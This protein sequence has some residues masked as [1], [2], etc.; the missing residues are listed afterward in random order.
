MNNSSSMIEAKK[1]SKSFVTG[2]TTVKAV[3]ES[4]FHI[5]AGEFVAVVG[6]SGSGK[7]TLLALLGALDH[8]TA[9]ELT[10]SGQSVAELRG[11]TLLQYRRTTIGFVFQN[12]NLVPNLSALENV[13]L[14][15][16]FAGVSNP[17]RVV[18]AKSLLKQVGLTDDKLQR[19]PGKL[20][21]GEQQR[22]AI[23]R[24]LANHPKL[25]LADEPTGNLD[26]QTSATI[27]D[28]LRSLV[29]DHQTTVMVVTH[30]QEI[31]K[32]ADRVF[33]IRDGVLHEHRTAGV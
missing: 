19:T 1:L 29:K 27:I 25:I 17:E 3:N 31:A 7:S 12:Y 33:E 18:R 13:M 10:I 28:L 23:A 2:A 20:S 32:R 22:L 24:A 26:H 21:G 11:A 16:E 14:A 6:K 8:P 5:G 9:G 4:T 15:M 30:D